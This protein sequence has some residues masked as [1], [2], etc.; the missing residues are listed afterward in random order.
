MAI[1]MIDKDKKPLPRFKRDTKFYWRLTFI[2]GK[3]SS[4]TVTVT[5][6]LATRK[7]RMFM[8]V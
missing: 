3:L 5:N 8:F 2:T 7:K 6:L 1:P 4:F